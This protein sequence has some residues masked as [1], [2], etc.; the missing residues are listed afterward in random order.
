MSI[1]DRIRE[2]HYYVEG[3]PFTVQDMRRSL[4]V[5]SASVAAALYDM[6]DE[7]TVTRKSSGNGGTRLTYQSKRIGAWLARTSLGV[8]PEFQW[9]GRGPL[10]WAR[11]A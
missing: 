2:S 11:C 10:E 4:N 1:K 9:Q 5:P 7:F 6:R 3:E 8:S